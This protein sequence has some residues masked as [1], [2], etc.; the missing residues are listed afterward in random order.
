MKKN[1]FLI[2]VL[3][4]ASMMT[5]V[6]CNKDDDNGGDDQT[7]GEMLTIEGTLEIDT[8]K[9][10]VVYIDNGKII[11]QCPVIEKKFSVTLKTLNVYAL[12]LM[13]EDFFGFPEGKI[14]VSN[15]NAKGTMAY[16]K[17]DGLD[18]EKI[19]QSEIE[20]WTESYIYVDSDVTISGSYKESVDSELDFL[21]ELFAIT[22]SLDLELKKG[23]NTFITTLKIT[24]NGMFSEMKTGSI[25]DGE[26]TTMTN[27][28][29][30]FDF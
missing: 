21:G 7:G 15:P 13:N 11:A 14:T 29:D 4:A 10:I 12:M 17:A 9:S 8:F 30:W 22:V 24:E 6:G 25:K 1:I 26:W 16:I 18:I 28:D 20:T 2:A 3:F 5:F 27:S 19:K 23:W